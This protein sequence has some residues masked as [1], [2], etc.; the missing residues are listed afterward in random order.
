MPTF[1]SS[2]IPFARD[3]ML[4]LD[5]GTV[6]CASLFG[7][8]LIGQWYKGEFRRFVH[9]KL[10]WSVFFFGLLAN[11]IAF[12]I[13]AYWIIEEPL[14]TRW[15]AVGYVSLILA[16]TAFFFAM[17]RILPYRTRHAFSIVGLL[18]AI[19][20]LI[21]P[22][23]LYV[24]VAFAAA[25]LALGGIL[26]FLRYS[27]KITS[28]DVKRN[29]EIV[30]ASFLVGWIGFLF[31]SD[32]IYYTLGEVFY[33]IGQILLLVG[34]AIFGY[35]L[36][37]TVALNELDWEKQI[38]GVYLIQYGGLLVFHYEFEETSGIDQFLTAAG[39]SGVQSLFQEI[40]RTE[41]GL[42]MVSIG[43]L[44]LIF[45]HGGS[46]TAVLIAKQPYQI[47]L[48]KLKDFVTRFEVLLGPIMGRF[49]GPMDAFAPAV[50]LAESIFREKTNK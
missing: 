40:T 19:I 41:S 24:F 42:N 47:F 29:V 39:I 37:Y 35:I 6:F 30:V 43:E 2:M 48:D 31:R 28:G 46:N 7:L 9:L 5:S 36:T 38:V 8:I 25:L 50:E 27:L 33:V 34:I 44:E 12:I 11:T 20:T 4:I 13:S 14:N 17:E 49:S 23:D 15:V 1:D 45:A 26:L 3:L 16:L 18:F 22:R 21:I 10:A 32:F